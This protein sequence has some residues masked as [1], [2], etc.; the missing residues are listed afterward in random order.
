MNFRK[1]IDIDIKVIVRVRLSVKFT[2]NLSSD[3]ALAFS[4]L[5]W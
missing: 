3:A 1:I 2:V 4:G 5:Q